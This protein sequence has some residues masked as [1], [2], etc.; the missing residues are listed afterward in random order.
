[1]DQISALNNPGRIDLPINQTKLRY[2]FDNDRQGD[3]RKRVTVDAV[4]I[5]EAP[6]VM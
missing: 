3:E 6:C 2:D 4:F 1:M 5:R